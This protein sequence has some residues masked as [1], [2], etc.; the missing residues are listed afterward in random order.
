MFV[1]RDALDVAEV[2]LAAPA[3]Q[4]VEGQEFRKILGSFLLFFLLGEDEG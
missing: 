1:G 2:M 3:A 4:G